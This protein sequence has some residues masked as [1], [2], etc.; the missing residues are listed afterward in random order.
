S[1][2]L[3]ELENR[4]ERLP[5][6]QEIVAY[7]RGPYCLFAAEAVERLRAHGFQARRLEDGVFD[8]RAR[9]FPIEGRR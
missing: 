9:G 1:M 2:P 5:R 8:W 7:C 3:K 6:D 4:L